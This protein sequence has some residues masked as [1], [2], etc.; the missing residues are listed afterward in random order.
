[1]LASCFGFATESMVGLYNE[2][3]PKSQTTKPITQILTAK[4]F[5]L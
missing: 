2:L 5:D 4:E 3:L 1:V